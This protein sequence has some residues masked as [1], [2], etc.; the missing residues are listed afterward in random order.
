MFV[1][2]VTWYATG[3]CPPCLFCIVN[4]FRVI[5]VI[6][7]KNDMHLI[8]AVILL[9]TLSSKQLA[10]LTDDSFYPVWPFQSLVQPRHQIILPV[11]QLQDLLS[12]LSELLGDQI[13]GC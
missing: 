4:A 12:V 8:T 9:Q 2:S 5:D 10:Q 11:I 3:T 7:V 1:V 6:P 13:L